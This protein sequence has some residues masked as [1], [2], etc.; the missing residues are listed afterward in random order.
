MNVVKE[1]LFKLS[2]DSKVTQ[3]NVIFTL[4]IVTNKQILHYSYN[5]E[6][7]FIIDNYGNYQERDL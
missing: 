6:T 1:I 5:G 4:T 2:I 7:C 3:N